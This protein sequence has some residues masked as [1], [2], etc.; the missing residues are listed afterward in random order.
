MSCITEA[1]GAVRE[2]VEDLRGQFGIK[3]SLDLLATA[4]GVS[5]WKIRKLWNPE[6]QKHGF[7][8]GADEMRGLQAAYANHVQ[9]IESSLVARLAEVRRLRSTRLHYGEDQLELTLESDATR[10]TT[11]RR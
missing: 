8:L 3:K 1:Q 5:F 6:L 10:R 4:S 2:V 9:Q 7:A 11:A